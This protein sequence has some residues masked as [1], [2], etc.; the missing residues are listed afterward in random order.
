MTIILKCFS[1]SFLVCFTFPL[2]SAA[3]AMSA[4]CE[5]ADKADA[6]QELLVIKHSIDLKIFFLTANKAENVSWH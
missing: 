2:G 6:S 4:E 1:V 5:N 3:A